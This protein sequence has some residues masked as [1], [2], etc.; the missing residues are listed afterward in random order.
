MVTVRGGSE[1]F[2][3]LVVGRATASV[4]LPKA[5]IS[6]FADRL[7]STPYNMYRQTTARLLINKNCSFLYMYVSESY[8]KLIHTSHESC[9][10]TALILFISM[11]QYSN[12]YYYYY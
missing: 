1:A 5:I 4:L 3:S 7:R 6:V 9:L 2:N 10:N 11:R 8:Q 12:Y